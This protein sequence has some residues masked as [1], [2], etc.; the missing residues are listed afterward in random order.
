VTGVKLTLPLDSS[1]VSSLR[2]F[3]EDSDRL[4]PSR[5]LAA[6]DFALSLGTSVSHSEG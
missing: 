3:V 4:D 1:Q 2:A 6:S 5:D